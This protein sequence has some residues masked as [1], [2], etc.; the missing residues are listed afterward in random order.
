M[1]NAFAAI[2]CQLSHILG[3]AVHG[4]YPVGFLRRLQEELLATHAALELE[5][6]RREPAPARVAAEMPTGPI[7][8][9]LDAISINGAA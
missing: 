3:H 7:R 2:D 8:G 6:N 5:I 1:K 9:L 4:N